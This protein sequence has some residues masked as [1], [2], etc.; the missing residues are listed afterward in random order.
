[1]FPGHELVVLNHSCWGLSKTVSLSAESQGY[2]HTALLR[3]ASWLATKGCLEWTTAPALD[4]SRNAVSSPGIISKMGSIPMVAVQGKTE[5]DLLCR[6]AWQD[7]YGVG[8]RN[9]G[10]PCSFEQPPFA[11][12]AIE[13]GVA[14]AGPRI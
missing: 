6:Y 14:I 9:K 7:K 10:P 5:H 4:G 2:E 13:T 8:N 12:A 3:S 1:M 11:K